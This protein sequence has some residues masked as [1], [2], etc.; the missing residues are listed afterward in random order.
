MDEKIREQLIHEIAICSD[1]NIFQIFSALPTTLSYYCYR[2]HLPHT[3]IADN[4]DH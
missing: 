1:F 2:R 3:I 4:D